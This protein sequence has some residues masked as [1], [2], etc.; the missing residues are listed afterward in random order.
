M[1]PTESARPF[2]AADRD[3]SWRV[4]E[5]WLRFARDVTVFSPQISGETDWPAWRPRQDITLRFGHNG[6][7]GIAIEKRFMRRRMQVFRLL[8]KAFV[9]LRHE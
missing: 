4:S 3:F 9:H 1:E 8:M 5:Y 2:T 6:Q 7:A